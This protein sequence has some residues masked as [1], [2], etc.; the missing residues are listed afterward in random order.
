MRFKAGKEVTDNEG[1][2]VTSSPLQM[3][4]AGKEGEDITAAGW[5]CLR[6]YP[7]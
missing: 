3:Q 7:T 5:R 1:D 4:A 2:A 6:E